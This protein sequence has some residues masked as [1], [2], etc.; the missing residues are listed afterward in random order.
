M[1]H[2]ASNGGKRRLE[3]KI[4]E[5]TINLKGLDRD[6]DY[7]RNLHILQSKFFEIKFKIN[8]KKYFLGKLNMLIH[9]R[10]LTLRK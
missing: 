10:K 7:K 5:M 6:K 9:Q 8:N 4:R 3:S 1:I 2:I